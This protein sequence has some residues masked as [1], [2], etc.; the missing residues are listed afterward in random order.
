MSSQDL[1]E[2]Q[3]R[4]HLLEADRRAFYET[5]QHTISQ[6]KETIS[7]LKD[8]VKQLR[9]DLLHLQKARGTA[10]S[11]SA[12]LEREI[13]DAEQCVHKQKSRKDLL[14][15]EI[16]RKEAILL[17]IQ[18]NLNDIQREIIGAT[19]SSDDPLQKRILDLEAS[20][21]KVTI[22]FNEAQGIKNTYDQIVKRLTEE[23]MGYQN[24]I[25]EHETLIKQKDEDID[26]V[27]TILR[28]ARH[29]KQLVKYELDQVQAKFDAQREAREA[30]ILDKRMQLE[31][32]MQLANRL[33][34]KHVRE[35]KSPVFEQKQ[36]ASQ[37]VSAPTM[38]DADYEQ[39]SSYEEAF[40]KLKEVTGL[41]SANE[42][43]E[44]FNS[45]HSTQENLSNLIKDAEDKIKV[46]E[47]EKATLSSR[48]DE[49]RFAGSG[50]HK[51]SL[52]TVESYEQKFE[53]AKTKYNTLS[54]QYQEVFKVVAAIKVAIENLVDRLRV[55]KIP[56]SGLPPLRNEALTDTMVASVFED[57]VVR[58][59]KLVQRLVDEGVEKETIGNS[60]L[61]NLADMSTSLRMPVIEDDELLSEDDDDDTVEK[62][63]DRKTLKQRSEE[64]GST[65]K[66]L[67]SQGSISKV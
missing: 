60:G 21:D 35:S 33:E 39:I 31:K 4:Y 61:T 41:S 63:L 24:E 64:L 53:E 22:K 44:K 55:V 14:Q 30:A 10:D 49:L 16:Q 45:Q 15:H 47:E 56:S 2:L 50:G 29:A 38:V 54:E 65:V 23:N 17:S 32:K 27:Q 1:I 62:V 42:I 36:E 52:S 67:A 25:T 51:T 66:G 13:R 34:E 57:V 19:P 26:E 37:E 18:D 46:L 11:A 48:L 43:I 9:Q 6:N 8:Q 5:S 7:L 3:R 59:N 40:A 28:D 20:L 12:A 58:L